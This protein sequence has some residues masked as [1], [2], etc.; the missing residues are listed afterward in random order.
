MGSRATPTRSD[1]PSA[2]DS[3][4]EGMEVERTAADTSPGGSK[5]LFQ[6]LAI[7]T[8]LVPIT[9]ELAKLQRQVND[10]GR[11]TSKDEIVFEGTAVRPKENETERQLLQRLVKTYWGLDLKGFEGNHV[12][13]IKQVH[14]LH[15]E[16]SQE[17]KKLLAKFLNLS[18]GSN[19]HKIL[20]NR[21]EFPTSGVTLYR[22]LHQQT[23]NDKR[24]AFLSRQMRGAK[25]ITRFIFDSVSGRLKVTFPDGTRHTFSEA[26]DLLA[27]CSPQLVKEIA[28]LD[29]KWKSCKTPGCKPGQKARGPRSGK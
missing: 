8:A 3:G 13:E 21:P 10:Q 28:E 5:G 4:G 24:L 1:I 29:K 12:D 26:S 11:Q 25:E 6:T 15:T 17:K 20:H 22:S 27:R 9:S 7:E 2:E 23:R 18:N 19:F 16:E 14:W